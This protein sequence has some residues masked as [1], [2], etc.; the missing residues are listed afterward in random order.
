MPNDCWSEVF[1]HGST[2]TIKSLLLTNLSYQD[3][4]DT[5][6]NEYLVHFQ[7][8]HIYHTKT[9]I[10]FKIWS[11]WV[12]PFEFLKTLSKKFPDLWI[13]CIWEEEGGE[14]GAWICKENSVKELQWEGP[15]IEA[16]LHEPNSS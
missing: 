13:R 16:Y 9:T 6:S 1:F 8:R 12:P 11:P 15:C 4:F 7:A 10:T 5:D 2:N 14:G 3:L